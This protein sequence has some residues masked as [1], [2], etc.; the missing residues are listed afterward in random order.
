VHYYKFNIGDYAK[1]TRHLTNLEDLAYRRLLELYY[2]DESPLVNDVKKLSRLIMMRENEQEVSNVLDDFFFLEDDQWKQNRVE[3]ELDEYR[4]KAETARGN[5]KKG[6]RPKKPSNNP[7]GSKNNPSGSKNKPDSNPEITGSKANHKPLTTNQEPVTK[8]QEPAVSSNRP[9]SDSDSN[10]NTMS[11][12]ENYEQ[13]NLEQNGLVPVGTG[14][15]LSPFERFWEAY[16]KKEKRKDCEKKW[17]SKKLD[18]MIDHLLADIKNRDA[19]CHN[20]RIENGIRRFKSGPLPYLNGELWNNDIQPYPIG[21]QQV[22][23]QEKQQAE[24]D[25]WAE[26]DRIHGKS[27]NMSGDFKDV[28]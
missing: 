27:N 22:T 21:G 12:L 14:A 5:G 9:E 4:S 11:D 7:V 23:K 24:D 8:N 3:Q 28:N 20:W 13:F 10:I 25:E 2:S 15:C 1:C 26:F 16:G 19:N 17:N 18:P 6:G